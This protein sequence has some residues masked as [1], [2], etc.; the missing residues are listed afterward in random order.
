SLRRLRGS[1][2]ILIPDGLK[3]PPGQIL[4]PANPNDPNCRIKIRDE[5]WTSAY[6]ITHKINQN[7]EEQIDKILNNKNNGLWH[8]FS[9]ALRGLSQTGRLQSLAISLVVAIVIPEKIT[10]RMEICSRIKEI[11]E[12]LKTQPPPSLNELISLIKDYS[13]LIIKD[14]SIRLA[15]EKL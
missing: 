1:E 11:F 6:E 3:P 5:E 8:V 9:R 15:I 12:H 13:R 7:L 4:R 2:I 14:E 10:E